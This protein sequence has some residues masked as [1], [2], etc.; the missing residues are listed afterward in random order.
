[1]KFKKESGRLNIEIV[2]F[3][4][5]NNWLYITKVNVSC[6]KNIINGRDIDYQDYTCTKETF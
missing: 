2:N 3:L 1:M 4:S 6:N 5:E